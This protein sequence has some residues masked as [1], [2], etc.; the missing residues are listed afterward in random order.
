MSRTSS[1]LGVLPGAASSLID[2]N[3]ALTC[4]CIFACSS[5]LSS[6]VR[7]AIFCCS[8]IAFRST[9]FLA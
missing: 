3:D 8:T 2:R 9:A 7:S 4:S 5:W 1:R 6:L